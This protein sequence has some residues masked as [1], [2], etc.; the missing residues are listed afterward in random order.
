MGDTEHHRAVVRGPDVHHSRCAPDRLDGAGRRR[1]GRPR[2]PGARVDADRWQPATHV[3]VSATP[4][5]DAPT[6]RDVFADGS[7]PGQDR[8]R[9]APGTGACWRAAMRSSPV[10]GALDHDRGRTPPAGLV[11]FPA[12]RSSTP[13]DSVSLEWRAE[14][15]LSDVATVAISGNGT[16]W[17]ERDWIGVD[18]AWS[19]TQPVYGDDPGRRDIWVRFRDGAGNWSTP[20]RQWTIYEPEASCCPRRPSPVRARPVLANEPSSTVGLSLLLALDARRSMGWPV[21]GWDLERRVDGDGAWSTVKTGCGRAVPR[22]PDAR[23][24]LPVPRPGELDR[25]GRSR[26]GSRG[27][28]F[29]VSRYTES[30]PSITWRRDVDDRPQQRLLGRR[31]RRSTAAG[32]KARSSPRRASCHGSHAE[33]PIAARRRSTS[34]GR[35]WRRSISGRRPIGRR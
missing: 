32:S 23:P 8:S 24:Q 35:S 3:Q 7:V 34:T 27:P 9:R 5:F 20:L 30:S 2:R 14:D 29:R 15:L 19:L 6:E 1:D 25:T 26:R 13:Y 17:E 11:G 4:D 31:A 12:A 18:Q 28:T 16:D 21:V 33:V 10:A 22:A